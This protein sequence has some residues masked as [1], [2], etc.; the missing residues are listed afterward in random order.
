M[1]GYKE[2][3]TKLQTNFPNSA[4]ERHNWIEGPR[5]TD[6][7]KHFSGDNAGRVVNQLEKP[8]WLIRQLLRPVMTPGGHVLIVGTG[9]GG[10][11]RGCIEEGWS[12][13]GIEIDPVQYEEAKRQVTVFDLGGLGVAPQNAIKTGRMIKSAFFLPV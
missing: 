3:H 4:K 2:K 12:A 1:Q 10:D 9:A 6:F 13:S 8:T 7:G 5:V 11:V